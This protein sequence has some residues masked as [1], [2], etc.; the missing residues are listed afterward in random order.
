MLALQTKLTKYRWLIVSIISGFVFLLSQSQLPDNPLLWLSGIE[1]IS[2]VLF[3]IGMV[4]H[5]GW[6]LSSLF[7]LILPTIL[8]LIAV[9][10]HNPASKTQ[11]AAT[12]FTQQQLAAAQQGIEAAIKQLPNET[13]EA[14]AAAPEPTLKEIRREAFEAKLAGEL[15]DEEILELVIEQ[16]PVVRHQWTCVDTG[17]SYA[18]DDYVWTLNHP[19]FIL[20]WL[21]EVGLFLVT[22]II[23]TS[24]KNQNGKPTN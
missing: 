7:G 22:I 24:Y 1:I 13:L 20:S 2:L 8:L 18:D 16:I 6:K 3:A 17:C 10:A 15:N 9:H 14:I 12:E 19:D 21:I 4:A 5:N 11:A 23:S